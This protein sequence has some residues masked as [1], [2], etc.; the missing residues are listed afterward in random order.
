MEWQRHRMCLCHSIC[1][2]TCTFEFSCL[3]P[4]RALLLCHCNM[5]NM[6]WGLLVQ[7]ATC[8]GFVLYDMSAGQARGRGIK[9]VLM[10]VILRATT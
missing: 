3:S 5:L 4:R 7:N 10:N 8:I 2:Q 6:Q 9:P 1:H